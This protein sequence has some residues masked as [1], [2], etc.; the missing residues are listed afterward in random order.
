MVQWHIGAAASSSK[1]GFP[2]LTLGGSIGIRVYVLDCVVI[3]KS[4]KER[5]RER[6]RKKKEERKERNEE[7]KGGA[8]KKGGDIG[9]LN[10]PTKPTDFLLFSC[11]AA[12]SSLPRS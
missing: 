2:R 6:E 11:Y 3:M 1:G 9:V 7:K 5:E 8:K 10:F 12:S 4:I